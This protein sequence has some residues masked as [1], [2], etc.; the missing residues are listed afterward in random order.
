MSLSY[1][2][3]E[4]QK[5]VIPAHAGTQAGTRVELGPGMR[6]DDDLSYSFG[7]VMREIG[8]L[9]VCALARHERNR[10]RNAVG[11]T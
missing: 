3:P 9:R 4:L 7:S 8:R 6:R 1:Q 5:A 2:K 11:A 10:P